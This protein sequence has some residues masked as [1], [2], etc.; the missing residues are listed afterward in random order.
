MGLMRRA[1]QPD[2]SG[3]AGGSSS[4]ST[5]KAEP[6]GLPPPL[7]QHA[8]PLPDSTSCL[9]APGGNARASSGSR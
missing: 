6:A 9:K 4:S 5:S 8:Q 3:G 7:T 2:G 1:Q